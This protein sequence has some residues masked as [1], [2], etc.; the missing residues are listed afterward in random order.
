MAQRV[1]SIDL[2]AYAIKK[3]L[4]IN[5][6]NP[7]SIVTLP[8]LEEKEKSTIV[9]GSFH[10]GPIYSVR[11]KNVVLVAGEYFFTED[12]FL[13]TGDLYFHNY[14][15]CLKYK[16]FNMSDVA[17]GVELFNKAFDVEESL[18]KYER[19][20]SDPVCFLSG[21]P[22]KAYFGHWFMEFLSKT[23]LFK[24]YG[25]VHK[26]II[27]DELPSSFFNWVPSLVSKEQSAMKIF[28]GEPVLFRDVVV[29]SNTLCRNSQ[30]GDIKIWFD[31]FYQLREKAFELVKYREKFKKR[32]S[33]SL[34][35]IARKEGNSRRV[36]DEEDLIEAFSKTEIEVKKIFIEDFSIDEQIN[37]VASADILMFSMGS[38]SQASCFCHRNAVVVELT[39]KGAGAFFGGRLYAVLFS[40]RYLRVD[41]FITGEQTGTHQLDRDISIGKE[42]I[43]AL[44]DKLCA[45]QELFPRNGGQHFFGIPRLSQI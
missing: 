22:D 27:S 12:G 37:L 14:S 34:L 2:F 36:K 40:L 45:M 1:Q 3:K 15:V 18:L 32:K 41:C 35:Y 24:T 10:N 6:I 21:G 29:S 39:P 23:F 11:L 20:I 30:K 8:M 31:G 42:K 5:L 4:D 38:G 17:P 13:I 33:K 16:N 28:L 7:P 43:K 9:V 26:Y 44:V 19:E 25:D